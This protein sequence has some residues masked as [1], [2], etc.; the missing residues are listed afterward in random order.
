MVLGLVYVLLGNA[1]ALLA[2]G[3]R[4]QGMDREE[5]VAQIE[6]LQAQIDE[7]GTKEFPSAAHDPSAIQA[8]EEKMAA[9]CMDRDL[10][11]NDVFERFDWRHPSNR[12]ER[13]HWL[14][15][16]DRLIGVQERIREM[17]LSD[18]SGRPQIESAQ[19]RIR[20]TENHTK[21]HLRSLSFP[22]VE[23][24]RRQIPRERLTVAQQTPVSSQWLPYMPII[25]ALISA[26]A[27]VAAAYI[28]F[29]AATRNR[30]RKE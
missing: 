3:F 26:L 2:Q 28:G 22:F 12:E 18:P 21:A 17:A 23:E 15:L 13:D 27:T 30:D 9:L 29:R 19:E 20:Y 1:V 5:F 16:I 25:V 10:L 14:Q 6:R 8:L 11:W 4:A 7:I 24:E